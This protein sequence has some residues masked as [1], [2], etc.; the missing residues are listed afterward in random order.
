MHAVGPALAAVAHVDSSLVPTLIS[1]A[2]LLLG[3]GGIAAVITAKGQSRNYVT[4][5]YKDLNEANRQEAADERQKA[6]DAL[7]RAERAEFQLNRWRAHCY[8][9][10][11]ELAAHGI[12]PTAM[13]PVDHPSEAP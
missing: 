7:A 2:V 12:T 11:D 3:G 10:R 4:T 8:A 6:A 13:P 5:Q 1:I 9:L